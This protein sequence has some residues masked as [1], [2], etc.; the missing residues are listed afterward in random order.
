[1]NCIH[2]V[3]SK[4]LPLLEFVV[5]PQPKEAFGVFGGGWE[6]PPDVFAAARYLQKKLR[7]QEEMHKFGRGNVSLSI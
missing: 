3:G 6:R 2:W 7:H 4:E 1:V 5:R